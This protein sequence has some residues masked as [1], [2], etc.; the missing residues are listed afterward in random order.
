MRII[1]YRL[2][3]TPKSL[4]TNDKLFFSY[5]SNVTN[6]G[7]LISLGIKPGDVFYE[8]KILV[9]PRR[10]LFVDSNLYNRVFGSTVGYTGQLTGCEVFSAD[11]IE[12][13]LRTAIETNSVSFNAVPRMLQ[14]VYVK[15]KLGISYPHKIW[16]NE[17]VIY[18]PVNS[19]D[20]I[21][22]VSE[23]KHIRK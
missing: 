13:E 5:K 21:T 4:E 14:N 12:D 23:A 16:G 8:T 11:K 1:L 19:R 10:I 2:S 9:D 20:Y 18:N 15:G 7:A 6:P 17:V 3:K 22:L